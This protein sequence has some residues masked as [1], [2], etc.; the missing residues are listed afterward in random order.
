M[1]IC[2]HV[3]FRAPV[4]ATRAAAASSRGLLQRK[5]ACGGTHRSDKECDDCRKKRLSLQGR[6]R[7]L[8]PGA[9]NDS[10]V[11]PVVHE[12]LR[13]PG[14]PLDAATRTF[15]EPRFGYDFSHVRVHTDEQAAES[16]YA[17]NALAYTVGHDVV[18]GLGRYASMT[19]DGGRLLAHE[20]THVIQQADAGH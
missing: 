17:V 19:S 2:T 8:G 18:F 1:N 9:Q 7:S 10:Y 16:A 3:P 5:C 15:M 4:V 11:P 12:V 14:E 13:S 6:T 20:L